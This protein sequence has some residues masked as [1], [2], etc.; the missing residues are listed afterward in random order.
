MVTDTIDA[1]MTIA[2]DYTATIIDCVFKTVFS[3]TILINLRN[4]HLYISHI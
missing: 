4:A 3:V 1:K 2:V